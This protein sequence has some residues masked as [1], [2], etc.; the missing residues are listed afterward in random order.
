MSLFKNLTKRLGQAS[1]ALGSQA[2]L[3]FIN[4]KI[5]SFGTMTQLNIDR[6]KR[7]INV[8]LE[9]KGETQ[10]LKAEFFDYRLEEIGGKVFIE[11]SRIQTSREWLNTLLPQILPKPR[12]EVPPMIKVL[13]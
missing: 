13:L 6:E 8:E 4:Q 10:S 3:V 5:A 7:R 9:L 12:F 11:F 2:A 1:N